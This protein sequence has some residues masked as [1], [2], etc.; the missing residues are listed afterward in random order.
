MTEYTPWLALLIPIALA[1]LLDRKLKLP[2]LRKWFGLAL[3]VTGATLLFG[4]TSWLT[5]LQFVSTPVFA[6]VAG[7]VL[8]ITRN[9][10]RP[11]RNHP[12]HPLLR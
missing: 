2:A 4:A 5:G 8:L 1:V 9:K 6:L 10:Y 7:V 3:M 11:Q 12:P